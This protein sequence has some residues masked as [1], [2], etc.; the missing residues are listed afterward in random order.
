M[1]AKRLTRD[2]RQ[3][4]L[5]GQNYMICTLSGQNYMMHITCN[6]YLIKNRLTIINKWRPYPITLLSHFRASVQ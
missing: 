3:D 5:S 4:T 1:E 6:L 2:E